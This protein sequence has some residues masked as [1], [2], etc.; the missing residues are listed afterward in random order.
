MVMLEIDR[1]RHRGQFK[2]R[3]ETRFAALQ[4]QFGTFA[5]RD[6]TANAPVAPELAVSGIDRLTGNA[7]IHRVVARFEAFHFEITESLPRLKLGAMRCPAAFRL[8]HIHLPAAF[9]QPLQRL[10]KDAR[11]AGGKIGEAEVFVLLP[12][13]V[14][15]QVVEALQNLLFFLQFL[16]DRADSS[17]QHDAEKYHQ[18]DH[19][20][21]QTQQFSFFLL[22]FVFERGGQ[23]QTQGEIAQFPPVLLDILLMFEHRLGGIG[24]LP[25]RSNQRLAGVVIDHDRRTAMFAH[26]GFHHGLTGWGGQ[27]AGKQRGPEHPA[28]VLQFLFDAIPRTDFRQPVM[29]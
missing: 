23:R 5:R 8:R 17:L 16:E 9:S 27:A 14:V 18:D 11:R 29:L 25:C 19:E 7:D 24:L 21:R 12:E 26:D 20:Q 1:H 10:P 15:G 28:G 22:P 6:V 4:G 3:L 13:P 2:E